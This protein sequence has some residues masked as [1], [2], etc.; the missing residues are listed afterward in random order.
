MARCFHKNVA[1]RVIGT[2]SIGKT[3]QVKLAPKVVRV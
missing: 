3:G 1:N 2:R